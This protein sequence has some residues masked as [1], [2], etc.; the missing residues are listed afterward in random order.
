MTL[1]KFVIILEKKHIQLYEKAT[2][3]SFPNSNPPNNKKVKRKI[4]FSNDNDSDFEKGRC[5][6]LANYALGMKE[7][8]GPKKLFT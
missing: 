2:D 1:S 7:R 5:G 6:L 3:V 8:L 4:K